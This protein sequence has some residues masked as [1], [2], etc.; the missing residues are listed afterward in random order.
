MS[1]S[2]GTEISA[3]NLNSTGA[4]IR[5]YYDYHSS[6]GTS[7]TV[8]YSFYIHDCGNTTPADTRVIYYYSKTTTSFYWGRHFGP[9]LKA[10]IYKLN[11][12]GT[13]IGTHQICNY[14]NKEITYEE[15]ATYD[16]LKNWFGSV[17][18]YYRIYSYYERDDRGSGVQTWSV[19]GKPHNSKAN[20]PIRRF[21]SLTDPTYTVG[22]EL[23][24]TNLNTGDFG[25]YQD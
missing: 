9:D 18:G 12:S 24:A 22:D 25:T 6:R 7:H 3:A 13:V 2:V 14:E 11:S 8:N 19:Y 1:F 4:A 10:Y 23:S 20:L 5:T 21:T 16:D 15:T 17:E